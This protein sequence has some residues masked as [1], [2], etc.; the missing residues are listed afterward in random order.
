LEGG[1]NGWAVRHRKKGQES[2]YAKGYVAAKSVE[3]GGKKLRL[4]G[5]KMKVGEGAKNPNGGGEK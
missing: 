3:R 2:G 4:T 5:G 1:E